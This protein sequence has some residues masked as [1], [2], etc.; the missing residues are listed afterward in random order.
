LLIVKSEDFD[1]FEREVFIKTFLIKKEG[2]LHFVSIS[3]DEDGYL[4]MVSAHEK[5]KLKILDIVKR[6]SVTYQNDNLL[7]LNILQDFYNQGTSSL[8][9]VG[10]IFGC[11]KQ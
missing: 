1:G 7:S 6:G 8:Q 5:R 9:F 2:I 3:K 11:K 10:C 4:Q